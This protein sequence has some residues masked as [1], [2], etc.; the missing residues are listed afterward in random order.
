MGARM[1]PAFELC[2][3]VEALPELC[4]G[5]SNCVELCGGSTASRC[6]RRGESPTL[7]CTVGNSRFVV[8]TNFVKEI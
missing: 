1:E 8:V 6:S 7:P 5:S 2:G 4:G 3:V